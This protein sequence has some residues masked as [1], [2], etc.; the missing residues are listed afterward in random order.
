MDDDPGGFVDDEEVLV[1]EGD[2][3]LALL[4]LERDGLGFRHCDLERLPA[5]E[6]V[7][8]GAPLAVDA[9]GAGC[10]QPLGLAA[11]S[12]LG[13]RG[14]KAVEPLAGRLLRNSYF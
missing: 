5:F 11:G 14:E 3:Q 4:G 6:P 1:L 10:Q 8:L 12:D 13:E 7:T 9:D 2:P